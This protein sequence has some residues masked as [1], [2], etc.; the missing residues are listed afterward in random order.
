MKF[1][2]EFK[3][4]KFKFP[5]LI[6]NSVVQPYANDEMADIHFTYSRVIYKNQTRIKSSRGLFSNI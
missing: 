5:F 4:I 1:T 2:T 6:I 3:T